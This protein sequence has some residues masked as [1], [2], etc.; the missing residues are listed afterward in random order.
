MQVLVSHLQTLLPQ[1]NVSYRPDLPRTANAAESNAIV[2]YSTA[3]LQHVT[4]DLM[5]LF[6]ALTKPC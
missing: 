4:C 6:A 3:A 5:Q 1:G 2:V